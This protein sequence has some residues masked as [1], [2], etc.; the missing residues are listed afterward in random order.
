MEIAPSTSPVS[1]LNR[2]LGTCQKF[3]SLPL[4]RDWPF[5]RWKLDGRG[6]VLLD[7]RIC[8][9]HHGLSCKRMESIISFDFYTG[10]EQFYFYFFL[11]IFSFLFLLWLFAC[12]AMSCRHACRWTLLSQ[13]STSAE[14]KNSKFNR[15]QKWSTDFT[16]P[17][18]LVIY[19]S[20]KSQ[21]DK[22]TLLFGFGPCP[23]RPQLNSD[24]LCIRSIH[25]GT[26]LLSRLP[27]TENWAS[28]ARWYS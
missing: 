21:V 18:K 10:F 4:N 22:W 16:L 27:S 12:W 13:R 2:L 19:T 20:P 8:N 26:R 1:C 7:P 24:G 9:A 14:K 11:F 25:R 17:W 23:D 15:K 5:V 3:R 6:I 28:K